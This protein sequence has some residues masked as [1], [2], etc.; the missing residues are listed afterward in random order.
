VLE[1]QTIRY[2]WFTF[3]VY[4]RL[5]TWIG[6]SREGK[7]AED[8]CWFI[9]LSDSTDVS[10]PT[11]EGIF[12]SAKGAFGCLRKARS[13]RFENKQ[14]SVVTGGTAL[15]AADIHLQAVGLDT[16][17]RVFFIVSDGY[18]AK[19]GA[20]T[21]AT[22]VELNALKDYGI[23]LLSISE[24]LESPE[25]LDVVWTVPAVQSSAADPQALESL[26][27]ERDPSEGKPL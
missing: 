15:K 16:A 27:P 4:A 25:A 24:A 7:F 14:V 3:V 5:A 18:R 6:N 19:F 20:P 26:R 11:F 10:A 21:A 17:R 23:L 13:V 8:S 9:S 22:T 1:A 2:D 12:L